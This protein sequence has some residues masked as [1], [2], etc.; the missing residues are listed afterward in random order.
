ME[1]VR[2]NTGNLTWSG[3]CSR[4]W[5]G[6]ADPK[7]TQINGQSGIKQVQLETHLETDTDK[8]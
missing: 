6:Q 4:R 8:V 7:V 2:Y 1:A 3:C 5:D